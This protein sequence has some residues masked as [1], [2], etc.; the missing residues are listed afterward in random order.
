MVLI[1]GEH[2]PNDMRSTLAQLQAVAPYPTHLVARTVDGNPAMIK[3]MLDIGVQTLLVPM[4]EKHK[5][6]IAC[7]LQ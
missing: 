7:G 5:R 3:Q 1:D 2:A 4:V 6:L